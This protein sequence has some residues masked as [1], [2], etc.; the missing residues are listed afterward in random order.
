MTLDEYVAA[1]KSQDWSYEYS[2]DHRAWQAGRDA[3]HLLRETQRR[4]DPNGVVW[5]QHAPRDSRI[6]PK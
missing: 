6:S 1:L 2:D 4:I 3:M 5:N